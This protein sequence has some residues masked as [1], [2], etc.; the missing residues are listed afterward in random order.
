MVDNEPIT[1]PGWEDGVGGSLAKLRESLLHL[2]FIRMNPG[3]A[4]SRPRNLTTFWL[5][6]LIRSCLWAK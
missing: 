4:G 5:K 2:G 1:C 3:R 6:V